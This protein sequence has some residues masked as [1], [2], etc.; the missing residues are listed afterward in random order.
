MSTDRDGEQ[1]SSGETELSD[2]ITSIR[3]AKRDLTSWLV[4]TYY[5]RR[6]SVRIPIVL[7]AGWITS[8]IG[9]HLFGVLAA[10]VIDTLPKLL[11]FASTRS[12]HNLSEIELFVIFIGIFTAFAVLWTQKLNRIE[13]KIDDMTEIATDGGV[14]D[15][16]ESTYQPHPRVGGAIGG[17]IAGGAIGSAWG[18]QGAFMGAAVG[19]VIG[20]EIMRKLDPHAYPAQDT[21]DP[22]ERGPAEGDPGRELE[23]D[24][25][26]F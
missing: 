21:R 15:P 14:R 7:G 5:R 22:D 13:S 1:P 26:R 19:A 10:R 17:A 20:D 9:G 18:A 11:E 25:S 3:N 12:L 4:R 24:N 23:R 2:A 16:P 6:L 8:E